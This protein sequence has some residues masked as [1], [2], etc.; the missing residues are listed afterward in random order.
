MGNAP[1]KYLP[2]ENELNRVGKQGKQGTGQNVNKVQ[3]K[4]AGAEISV[5]SQSHGNFV[6]LLKLSSIS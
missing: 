5:I 6:S 4:P 1:P 3:F 2:I